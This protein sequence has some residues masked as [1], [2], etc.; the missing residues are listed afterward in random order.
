MDRRID[1]IRWLTIS[2]VPVIKD[3][4]SC[5]RAS[6]PQLDK[7][8]VFNYAPMDQILAVLGRSP[9]FLRGN[10]P[11]RLYTESPHGLG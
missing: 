5:F 6:E 4:R 11:T 1:P 8:F 3:A 10:K 9:V 7:S 2:N